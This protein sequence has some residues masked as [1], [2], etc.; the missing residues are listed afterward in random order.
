M[1]LV[2]RLLD[3]ASLHVRLPLSK[4]YLRI[5]HDFEEGEG[6]GSI[7]PLTITCLRK[8]CR[9]PV[10]QTQICCP[11]VVSG[12]FWV[13]PSWVLC[14]GSQAE[15]KARQGCR[16]H[17]RLRA[18]FPTHWSLG[19]FLFYGPMIEVPFSCQLSPGT[20][21]SSWRPSTGP[22]VRSP[23]VVHSMAVCLLSPRPARAWLLLL[24]IS[25]DPLI[26]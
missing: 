8:M 18:L 11:A 3:A 21:L 6:N 25:R 17:P 24:P 4:S 23:W 19:T 14:S 7:F 20:A 15:M 2:T 12:R 1:H 5:L 16:C 13:Q 26:R 10:V 9:F 22:C